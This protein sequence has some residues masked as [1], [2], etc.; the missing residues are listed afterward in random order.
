MAEVC[1]TTHVVIIDDDEEHIHLLRRAL[2]QSNPGS[3]IS[4]PRMVKSY[5]DPAEAL[6]DLPAE[7]PVVILCDYR[8][9]GADGLDWLPDLVRANLGP[10]ILMTAQGDEQVATLAFRAGATDYLVKGEIFQNP[11]Q[12]HLAI[13]DALRRYKLE[14]RSRELARDLKLANAALEQK[15]QRLGELTETAHRFVDD[16]AHEFRTP[17]TVIKEFASIIRDGL[18]GPVTEKQTGF[19]DYIDAAVRDLA[20]MVDD[21]LDTSKLRAKALRVD[22]RP[23]QVADIIEAVRPAIATYA[24]SKRITLDEQIEPNLPLVFCDLEK[25]GRVIVNLVINAIKFSPEGGT[26]RLWARSAD[27]G[28]VSI[29]VT[30]HGPGMTPEE[31]AAVGERFEQNGDPQRSTAKGFGLGLSIARDL[32]RLNLGSMNITSAPGNGSTFSF[33]LPCWEPT[34]VLRLYIDT[35]AAG[36]DADSLTVLQV[37]PDNDPNAIEKTRQFL[38]SNC[39]SM[40]LVMPA[41]DRRSVLM[42]GPTSEPHKWIQRLES[43]CQHN[44]D[45]GSPT[46]KFQAHWIGTWAVPEMKNAVLEIVTDRLLGVRACA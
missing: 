41:V 6:A 33:S 43:V 42:V 4:Y 14:Q 20:Q 15:N 38:S 17:L 10:V 9:P 19:L 26:V 36:N 27:H 1:R 30:D 11:K 12:L 22:R 40:D 37:I 45:N 13:R 35:I 3:A 5:T 44:R 18:G 21:F 46:M 23:N 32:V 24:Q 34:S 16:V 2:K 28:D 25:A 7:G 29:G 8:M 31:L 39:Q